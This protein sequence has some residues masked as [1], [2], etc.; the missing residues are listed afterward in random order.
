MISLP[1]MPTALL[2]ILSTV[3]AFQTV[4]PRFVTDRPIVQELPLPAEADAFQFA[5]FGDRTGGPD[6]G[7]EVLKEA[8]AETNLLD[9]DLVMTVGDLINGYNT[10]D[11]WMRQMQEF[12]DVMGELA[13][14][15]FPVAGNHDVYW[16][17][18]DRPAEE[19]EGRYEE[20]FGPLWYGFRHKDC[21]FV[22]LYSEE[23]NPETGERNFNKPENHVMSGEQV[24]FLDGMLERTA[25]AQHVFVF[26][27]HPRWL[28]GKYG[29]SW[30]P[31]HARLAEAGNVRA[32]FAGHIH[33]M[34]YDG[35][36]DG[37]EYFALATIG[38]WQEGHS[39]AAGWLHQYH[40]VTVRPDGIELAAYPVGSAMDPRAVTGSASSAT[41]TIDK[42]F[43][44]EFSS[45]P[46]IE[47]EGCS[48]VVM[49][50]VT[51]PLKEG[52]MEVTAALVADEWEWTLQPDHVHHVLEPGETLEL[53]FRIDRPLRPFEGFDLPRL[54]FELAYL[55]DERRFPVR[56]RSMELPLMTGGLPLPPASAVERVADLDGERGWLEVPSNRL[57]LPDG[58]FTLEV[59]LNA[60]RYAL[61]QGLVAKTESSEYCL[62][63]SAGRPEFSV[64]LD[65]AYRRV[66]GLGALPTNRWV[67]LA[68]V[69]DGAEL[70]LY[71]DGELIDTQAGSGTR[72]TN[73]LPLIIGGDVDGNGAA[74]SLFDGRLDELRLSV[75]ARYTGERFTP[76]RRHA[77][78]DRTLLLLPFDGSGHPRARD[79]SGGGRD[80][81]L[82][83]NARLV[84]VENN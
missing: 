6:I 34:R 19:H 59:W 37:I 14:P 81:H 76:A 27:H 78:D 80:V 4:L 21:W 55:E 35:R 65:G 47:A 29:D 12:R 56:A 54:E 24:A 69:Y 8:V 46:E 57:P 60:D 15:W 58:P 44:V 31:T 43:K 63:A 52:R 77:T 40:L 17:G 11:P 13:M 71:V 67:H 36:R 61:R 2:T 25:D 38:G 48:G 33:A 41:A 79:V 53:P 49:A 18:P 73:N 22:V 32:V 62:F 64:H 5:I 45:V 75:V 16:R 3:I 82:R 72:K 68:G 51:N 28:G 23:A 83:G 66:R 74:T 70:R 84:P 1:T 42:R 7:I 26:V 10:V 9:P 20:H 30:E 50:Q 39:E